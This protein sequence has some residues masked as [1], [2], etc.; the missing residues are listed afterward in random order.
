MGITVCS[1]YRTISAAAVGVIAD[2]PLIELL[3]QERK[4]VNEGKTEEEAKSDIIARWQ[5]KWNSEKHGR[6]TWKLR[7]GM[8]PVCAITVT[9]EMMWSIHS[10]NAH[11]GHKIEVNL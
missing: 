3:A 11:V 8:T 5:E 4:D 2:I 7:K 9:N 10:S 6:W 1:G